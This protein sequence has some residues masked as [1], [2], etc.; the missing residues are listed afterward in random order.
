MFAVSRILSPVVFSENCR[1]ALRYA[2]GFASRFHAE[3]T[4]LH[5]VEP[6][7]CMDFDTTAG[8]EQ[9]EKCRREWVRRGLADLMFGLQPAVPVTDVCVNGDPAAEIIRFAESSGT[10]LIVI[11]TH[12]YGPFRRFL[13]GSVTAKVLH[14][15]SCAVWTGAHLERVLNRDASACDPRMVLCALDFGPQTNAA[16]EWSGGIASASQAR[17]ALLHVLPPAHDIG[18]QREEAQQSLE[19]SREIAGMEA[20]CHVAVGNVA[21]EI[22]GSARRLNADLLVIGRAQHKGGGRLRSTAYSILR[23]SGCPV[24][25]V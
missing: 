19:K 2:T 22:A 15:A 11:A 6:V 16:L 7:T 17:L 1:G 4:V 23:E 14:D 9:I 25:S 10:D 24:V 20:A 21:E 12:A 13:L 3:L 5:V 18:R 8:L